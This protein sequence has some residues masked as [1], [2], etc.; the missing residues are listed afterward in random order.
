MHPD[1]PDFGKPEC[2][3]RRL[4]VCQDLPSNASFGS[5]KKLPNSQRF[6]RRLIGDLGVSGLLSIGTT[7]NAWRVSCA[8]AGC[9][10]DH[11]KGPTMSSGSKLL[12]AL[13]TLLS[14]SPFTRLTPL[15][16]SA[17]NAPSVSAATCQDP[18]AGAFLDPFRVKKFALPCPGLRGTS[19]E[20]IAGSHASRSRGA[21]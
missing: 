12:T 21:C 7:I 13:S 6:R 20:T 9:V 18:L 11:R 19:M 8:A 17:E 16:R 1:C 14:S 2:R 3:V 4:P 10:W 15:T 5:P